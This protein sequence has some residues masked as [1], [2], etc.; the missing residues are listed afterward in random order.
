[1]C[2]ACGAV[3]WRL[4]TWADLWS[5][6]AIAAAVLATLAALEY[7]NYYHVQLQHFDNAADFKRLVS[8]KGFRRAHLA[9]AIDAWKAKR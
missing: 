5:P 2:R 9:R 1:M 6:D 8:G 4:A 7:V 3:V